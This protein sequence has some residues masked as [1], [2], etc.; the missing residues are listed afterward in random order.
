MRRIA[1]TT[2]AAAACSTALVAGAAAAPADKVQLCHGTASPSNPYV[3]ISV[4]ENAL[5]GHFDGTAPGHG[6]NNHPDFLLPAGQSDC[7]GGPGGEAPQ[8]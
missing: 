6:K 7:S 3:L 5:A 4:S 1:F 2:L 8:E